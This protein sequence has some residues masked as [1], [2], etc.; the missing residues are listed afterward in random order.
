MAHHRIHGHGDINKPASRKNRPG[1]DGFHLV[2]SHKWNTSMIFEEHVKFPSKSGNVCC[3]VSTSRTVKVEN[4]KIY[5]I[6]VVRRISGMHS[7][8]LL[9]LWSIYLHLP[10][11]LPSFEAAFPPNKSWFS[12]KLNPPRLPSW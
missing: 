2:S 11:E 3:W 7:P 10:T 4:W 1:R 5:Q 6:R 9:M 8:Q 12:G